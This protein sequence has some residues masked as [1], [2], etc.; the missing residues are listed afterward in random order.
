MKRR[1]EAQGEASIAVIGAG[2]VGT[3]I[4]NQ[5]VRAPAMRP[6]LVVNRTADRAIAAYELAGFASGDVVA[7]NDVGTLADAINAGKPAFT[8]SFEMIAELPIDI[9]VEATGALDYGARAILSSL[10]AG[11]HVVSFNAEIDGLLAYTFH[12]RAKANGVVYTIADGDQPG[13]ILRLKQDLEGMGF[14]PTIALNCKRHLDVHQSPDT[15]AAYSERDK[16]SA[17]M[18]TS[19]GDGTK[20]QVEMACVA[21]A[22]GMVP[23]V[24]GMHGIQTMV[25]KAAVDIPNAITASKQDSTGVVD[26]T[27]QGDFAAGIGIVARHERHSL[28]ETPMRFYKMG[29]GPDYFFFRPYH[30]VHL[31]LPLTLA[32]VIMDGEPLATVD[33]PHVAEVV[34][35]AKKDL[36][37][38]EQLDCIGGFSAYGHIDTTANAA[39]YLPI[40]LVQFAKTTAAIAQ[41]EPISLDKVELDGSVDV[42]K[43]WRAQLEMS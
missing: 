35:M 23:D 42:V 20:M 16:T 24:R 2:Y 15:G 33:S 4:V 34:A 1:A 21:N 43:L 18:T 5:L 17:I 6:A 12:E 19:F 7:S 40:G 3:S 38:A 8:E 28:V 22:T 25:E 27:H 29:D 41:D 31:E 13:V 30:L 39:G 37:D 9:A 36:G 14:H 32:D 11:Q 26:F 10:D